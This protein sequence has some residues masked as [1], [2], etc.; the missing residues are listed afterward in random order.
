[1]LNPLRSEREAFRF[2]VYVVLVA[3]VADRASC[4]SG[5]PCCDVRMD[6][7]AL[8]PGVIVW[9]AV[10]EGLYLRALRTLRG[11]G[12]AVPLAQRL[13]WHAA[14]VLWAV[15]LLGPPG[16]LAG[17]TLSGHMAEHLLIADLA[18][19]LM[20][21]GLRNPVLGF[22]LPRPL[23]VRL[24]RSARVR[25]GFRALRKPLVAIAVYAAVLYGWHVATLFEA[26][27]RNDAIHVLQHAEL[28]R[29]GG[30]RVVVGARAQAPPADRRPVEDRPHHLR[31]LP[32][33]VPGDELRAHPRAGLR[34]GLR[35][36][37]PPRA[38][39]A[40][41]P[42][43]RGAMMVVLDICIMVFALAYLFWRAGQ[44]EDRRQARRGPDRLYLT[45]SLPSM[46]PSRW[47]GT[48]Q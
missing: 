20:L 23:L 12:V 35:D 28:H 41:R 16:A 34:R 33:D 15:G 2:L 17:D 18:A 21:A 44:E 32:R 8:D 22:F 13:C 30:A 29:R 19:P 38:D 37:R 14:I 3:A 36:R 26:A 31:A 4:C 1:M 25:G 48:E 11:R 45:V 5:A 39:A 6:L 10:L 40:R 7:I 9:L 27:V 43:A 24:A 46:P 42:A 47:P